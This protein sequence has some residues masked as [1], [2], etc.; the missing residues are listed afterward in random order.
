ME[1]HVL[2]HLGAILGG[3]AGWGVDHLLGTHFIV[4]IGLVLGKA[5]TLYYVWLRYGTH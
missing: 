5:L 1:H 3:L 2:P 4:G